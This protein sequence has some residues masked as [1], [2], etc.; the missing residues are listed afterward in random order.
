[1]RKYFEEYKRKGE[2]WILSRA[3]SEVDWVI[4]WDKLKVRKVRVRLETLDGLVNIMRSKGRKRD[5]TIDD[6]VMK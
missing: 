6:T 4:V 5:Q 3:G 2:C 1:M